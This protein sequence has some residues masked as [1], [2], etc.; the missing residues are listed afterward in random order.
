MLHFWNIFW[1]FLG[2]LQ[3]VLKTWLKH[4]QFN[5]TTNSISGPRRRGNMWEF[6]ASAATASYWQCC[7][8]PAPPIELGDS[9][10]AT[11]WSLSKSLETEILIVEPFKWRP[12]MPCLCMRPSS[13]SYRIFAAV[14]TV[15]VC[16]MPHR[17]RRETKQHPSR[18]NPCKQ[19]SCSL[20]CLHFL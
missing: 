10:S 12:N 1:D 9:S 17:K 16:R 5:L 13:S 14:Y 20:L 2:E 7:S 8:A 3:F 4:W 15:L 18:A 6:T 19:L 11:W